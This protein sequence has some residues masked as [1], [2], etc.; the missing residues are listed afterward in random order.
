MQRDKE[1]KRILELLEFRISN[2]TNSLVKESKTKGIQ[3]FIKEGS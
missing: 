2:N 3:C 1:L